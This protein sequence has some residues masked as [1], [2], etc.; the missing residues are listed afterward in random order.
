MKKLE[1]L[2]VSK[3]RVNFSIVGENAYGFFRV[4]EQSVY[5]HVDTGDTTDYLGDVDRRVFVA[6]LQGTISFGDLFD[7]LV[8]SDSHGYV[9]A[10]GYY[11][12]P[13][14]PYDEAMSYL[15]SDRCK[16]TTRISDYVLDCL[17]N[18]D[19]ANRLEAKK[20]WYGADVCREQFDEHWQCWVDSLPMPVW[21][22]V[23]R[24]RSQAIRMMWRE[25]YDRA[26]LSV[27]LLAN[28]EQMF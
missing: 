28:G 27:S 10:D 11:V 9:D 17:A 4:G 26:V 24:V 14:I 6:F 13:V 19:E 23:K 16:A 8:E 15:A 25:G 5:L 12:Q 2:F 3:G 22:A 7:I 20:N 18:E 21:E 1:N